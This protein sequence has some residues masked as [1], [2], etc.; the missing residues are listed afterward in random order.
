MALLFGLIGCLI[1]ALALIIHQVK[2]AVSTIDLLS[3]SQS[4]RYA[5]GINPVAN[6]LK[7]SY[8]GSA[9]V[10]QDGSFGQA[11]P[12]VTEAGK[13]L[14]QVSGDFSLTARLKDI[15]GSVGL[16]LYS[17]PPI[18]Y[19]ESRYQ[20]PSLRLELS[21]DKLETSL[22]DGSS[23]KPQQQS[24]AIHSQ[25]SQQNQSSSLNI[26]RHNGQLTVA[27]DNKE[28]TTLSDDSGN[29]IFGSKQIWFGLDSPAADGTYTVSSLTAKGS[30]RV[31]DSS[32]L[33]LNVRTADGLQ[34]LAGKKRSNF[35]VGSAVSLGPLV[36]DPT[37]AGIIGNNFGS[38]TTENAAKFQFL[39]PSEKVYDFSG[40][41]ALVDVAARSKLQVQGHAL[42]FGEAN[43]L[44]LQ[45]KAVYDQASIAGLMQDYIQAVVG[46]YKNR[47]ASWDVVNEPLA[48]DVPVSS[49]A[50][51]DASGIYRKHLWDK[52]I[53]PSYIETA[54]SAAHQADPAAK[55]FI[56]D[57]GL[58]S[59]SDRWQAM[60]TI[61]TQLKQRN[62]P[63]D[64][65]GFQAHV[66]DNSDEV[67]PVVL[68]G[69]FQQLAKLGLQAHI[70]ELSVYGSDS[71]LQSEQYATITRVC[72]QTASC[73]GLTVWGP[74]GPAYFTSEPNSDNYAKI[75][76]GDD[77]LWDGSYKP[78]PALSAIKNSFK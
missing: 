38:M 11:N 60:L 31:V 48:E 28:V 76:P 30:F 63:L 26:S 58:E 24:F 37:Y 15:S 21:A 14:E 65:I 46:R 51:S 69:R 12:A 66:F 10:R 68:A 41:D 45:D 22:W 3:D 9:I 57:Y 6:G 23:D 42:I 7:V 17:R 72:L 8:T 39:H 27:I 5:S 25:Q 44:W 61:V 53:G 62:V 13:H 33:T 2:P 56:N 34:S 50:G 73:T 32:S 4:W 75:E 71:R 40:L 55:L 47:I 49:A 16:Q 43:P 52:A 64:G 59:D 78:R 1:F 18:I 70:S 74:G 67:D 36:S 29:K 20:T 19:D 54:L 35:N 77:G